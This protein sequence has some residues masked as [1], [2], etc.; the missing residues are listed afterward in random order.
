MNVLVVPGLP[1]LDGSELEA[2]ASDTKEAAEGWKGTR[3][4][5][6]EDWQKRKRRKGAFTRNNSKARMDK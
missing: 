2:P 5:K 4:E 1:S 6:E 3:E